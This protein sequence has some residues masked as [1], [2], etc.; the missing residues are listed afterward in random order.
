MIATKKTVPVKIQATKE[1]QQYYGLN[2]LKMTN[3]LGKQH[4][5]NEKDYEDDID[6]DEDEDDNDYEDV[7]L[8]VNPDEKQND[9]GE[10]EEYYNFNPN[11]VFKQGDL[12]SLPA[13]A[14]KKSFHFEELSNEEHKIFLLYGKDYQERKEGKVNL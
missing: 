2:L 13:N 5:N 6:D 12:D 4:P 14:T 10:E 1:A 8:E 11:P 7:V 3:D 9:E